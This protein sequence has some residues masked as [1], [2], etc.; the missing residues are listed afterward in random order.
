MSLTNVDWLEIDLSGQAESFP[1][2]ENSLIRL[3]Y[4]GWVDLCQIPSPPE[5]IEREMQLPEELRRPLVA[6]DVVPTYCYRVYLPKEGEWQKRLIE[7]QEETLQLGLQCKLGSEVRDEDWAENWKEFYRPLPV[8]ERLLILPSWLEAPA[9]NHR[10]I[11]LLDPGSAF[12][13]GYH[14]TTQLCLELLEQSLVGDVSGLQM[15]DVGT[16]SG[17]LSVGAW[18][19]GIRKLLG[20]DC[21][22]VA[23]KVASENLKANHIPLGGP[24]Q[25]FQVQGPGL[26]V[27]D[28]LAPVGGFEL[29]VANIVAQTLIELCTHLKAAL[30]PNGQLILGGIIDHRLADLEAAFATGGL[31]LKQRCE[32]DGWYALAM[33]HA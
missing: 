13:T 7:L 18:K 21:D 31:Q 4:P 15:L 32:R 27:P 29:I 3:G 5:E 9:G 25:M 24:V 30:A 14:P 26:G 2:L 10:E 22:A 12:G 6:A 17:I 1:Y 28:E 8:G 19:L 20:S 33:T 11:I 23:V 16:G